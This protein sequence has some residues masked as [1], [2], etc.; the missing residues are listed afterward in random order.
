M[1]AN[2]TPVRRAAYEVLRRCFE[3]DAWA[4]RALPAAIER[5][6]LEGRDRSQAQRLAFGAVQMR[7]TSDALVA[8]LDSRRARRL[9]P[10][11][12]AA[13]RLGLYEILFADATPDHAAVGEAVELAKRGMGPNQRRAKAASGMVNAILRRAARQRDEILG[14]FEDTTPDGAALAHSMPEWLTRM[15]FSELGPEPAG[16]LMAALNRPPETALRASSM[17]VD[18]PALAAE[19]TEAGE[20][21]RWHQQG[22]TLWPAGALV[23][24]G[25]LGEPTLAKLA[26]GEL[27]AQS[28]AAQAVV[29]LLGARPGRARS[30]PLR[31]SR[32]EDERPLPR[33]CEGEGDFVAVEQRRRAGGRGHEP[34]RAGGSPAAAGDRRRRRRSGRR[35]RAGLRSDPRGPALLRPRNARLAAGRALAQDA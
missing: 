17:R 1:K 31:R 4:D 20:Q 16:S 3:Q 8:R 19:L 14:G 25:R 22:T 15:W 32:A 13:L 21:V 10:P 5:Y 12:I 18:A 33:R 34:L 23:I 30:R 26:S 6:G 2:P 9:D 28:R 35:P 24:D 29:A 7:G 11:V 27:I